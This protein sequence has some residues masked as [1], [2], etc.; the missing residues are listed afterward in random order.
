MYRELDL[1]LTAEQVALKEAVHQFAAKVLRPTSAAL[2]R[3]ADPSDVVAERSPLWRALRETYRLG[4]H[5]YAIAAELGGFGL[6]AFEQHIVLEEMGWGSADLASAIAVAGL[7]FAI[8]AQTGNPALIGEFVRPF[9]ADPEA[10]HLGCW[11]ITEPEHGSDALMI[12]TP[13][14]HD[15]RSAGELI[16]RRDRDYYVLTGRKSAWVANGTIATHALVFLTLDPGRGMAGG[17]VAFVPL[18]LRGVSRGKPL[19]KMGQRALNQGEIIFDEVRIPETQMLTDP[20]LYEFILGRTLAMAYAVTAAIFTGVARAAYESAFDYARQ[21]VQGGR[22]I[23]EHQLVQK[24]LFDMFTRVEACR[25]LSRSAM[26]YNHA[27]MPPATEYSIAAKTFCS[28]AALEVTSSALQ[29][30]GGRGL[31]REYPIEK[32]F[33]DARA[34]LIQEG[35]NDILAL[36]AA[37]RLLESAAHVPGGRAPR[38]RLGRVEPPVGIAGG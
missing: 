33:R 27:T 20:S 15:P 4:Y 30:F 10:R 12:G 18:H 9:V 17:G 7:P 21:R 13:Q 26:V 38:G 19:D 23:S 3:V 11:A 37:R 31:S 2:D 14:F 1:H 35:S 34:S 36:V 8:L 29:L 28:E 5:R 22:A 25:A 24:R 32:L 16:A 6:S